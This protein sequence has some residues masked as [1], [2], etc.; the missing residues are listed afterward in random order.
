MIQP[1]RCFTL[2]YLACGLSCSAQQDVATTTPI[3]N[4]VVIFQENVA[5]D[6]Y[7]AT[8]PVARNPEGQPTFVARQDV[9]TPGVN[10][11]SGALLTR[12]PNSAAP[13]RLDRSQAVTC[14]QSHDYTREQ[15]AYNSGL[16]NKFIEFTS[17]SSASCDN[18]LGPKLVMGY[19]DGNTVTALWNYAQNFA[20]SDNFFAST[21]GP[22]TPGALNVISGQTHGARIVRDTGNGAQQVVDGSVVADIRPAFDDCV[23]TNLT[24]ATMSGRNIGD[25]L[26]DRGITWGWFQGGFKPSSRNADGTAVCAASD[27]NIAGARITDYVPHHQ[28]FQYYETTANQHHLPPSS[29]GMIGRTDQANHQYDMQDFWAAAFSGNLPAVSFLKAQAFQDGHASNSDPLD[30]QDFIVRALNALQNLKDWDHTAV[31]ITYDD[32]DGWY[33]HVMPPVV[34]PSATPADGLTGPGL[35][36]G[37]AA[38]WYGGRCGYGPRLPFLLISPWSR[39]NAV[40]HT[41]IDHASVVRFIEENWSLDRIGD[42]SFDVMAGSIMNLFDFRSTAPKLP[43]L[44]LDPRTG[45]TQVPLQ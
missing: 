23:A 1:R 34:S 15:K 30:E 13:F 22:S 42:Q 25:L 29:T 19:Y 10:G 38:G 39:S 17:V 36:G 35:C 20:M 24:T 21:Y 32:S 41:I 3:K 4:L 45:I 5:F 6:H 18:G 37:S 33:D 16:M 7:F 12:N 31:I 9:L 44:F 28:P 40:D 26:N 43:K 8:Y 11:L 27:T 14:S 2:A